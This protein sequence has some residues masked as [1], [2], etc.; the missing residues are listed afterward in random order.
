MNKN[1]QSGQ[2]QIGDYIAAMIGTPATAGRRLEDAS[3]LKSGNDIGDM[4]IHQRFDIVGSSLDSIE[5]ALGINGDSTTPTAKSKK[6]GKGKKNHRFDRKL[7]DNV[8]TTDLR[9]HAAKM[10]AHAVKMES[11]NAEL[12]AR[13]EK[14][15]VKTTS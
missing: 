4:T 13:L 2:S 3:R 8:L 11:E 9:A 12:K 14:V 10:E 6:Q 1:T 7:S 5:E 15:D